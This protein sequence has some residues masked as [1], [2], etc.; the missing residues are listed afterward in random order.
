LSDDDIAA[1]DGDWSGLPAKEQAAFAFTRKLTFAPHT[2]TAEDVVAMRKHYTPTQVLEVVVAVAGYNATNRWTDTLNIPAEESGAFFRREGGATDLSTFKTPTS[3]KYKEQLSCV[4]PAK[5]PARP[6]LEPRDKV[7]A[8]WRENRAPLL[9]LADAKG[10]AEL[11]PAGSPPNWVRLLA[12]FPKA[13]KGRVG[14]LKAGMEKGNVSPRLKAEIAWVAARHDRAW[15]ALAVAR[16]RLKALG[17]SDEQMF[18][19]DG[20]RDR[21]PEAERAALALAEAMTVSPWAITDDHVARVRKHFKDAEVAEI[22]HHACNAAFFDR[23]TEAARLPFD[24]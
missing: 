13:L 24:R 15:Y 9:P 19:L 3:T 1:L 17:F 6:A 18:A 4:A 10:A 5:V 12:T 23:V 14:G 16:E 7:E 8:I 20:G 22:V 2:L 21:L 11:W